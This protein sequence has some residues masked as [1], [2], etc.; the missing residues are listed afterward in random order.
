[1]TPRS[2][3]SG[4]AP[5]AL[6][7]V[8]LASAC[9]SGASE[10]RVVQ[11][12]APGQ[13]GT[14]VGADRAMAAGPAHTPADVQ[15]MQGMM[16]HHA[17]ALEMAAL[18]ESRE[19]GEAV[20]AMALRMQISQ[21]DEIA[22]IERWLSAHGEAA[23]GGDHAGHTMMPGML[24]PEQM[25]RLRSARG[26]EFDRLFLEYMIQHHEGAITM[27]RTLFATSGG[28]QDSEIFQFANDVETDQR[29]EIDRM[30]QV[31]QGGAR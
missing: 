10:P 19:A 6:G 12:G 30:R 8:L 1:M 2:R 14:V 29:I 22:L 25:A 18:V 17:Q 26:E 11:P 31:L 13:R 20:R 28:A 5:F 3:S 27:V 21:R 7:L 15:F 4:G 23:S 9:A 16:P 24:S